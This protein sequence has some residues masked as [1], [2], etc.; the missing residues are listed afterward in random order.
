MHEF[1]KRGPRAPEF[2]D[3]NG[4]PCVN[5]WRLTAG[6]FAA[7]LHG[8]AVSDVV[9][10]SVSNPSSDTNPDNKDNKDNRSDNTSDNKS[11]S[12]QNIT[13][14]ESVLLTLIGKDPSIAQAR[15]AEFLSQSRSTVALMLARL[16]RAGLVRREGSRKTG[17]WV[18]ADGDRR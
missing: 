16:Q 12:R 14:E 11:S 5:L 9:E 1:E 17:A 3:S 4:M 2:Q 15:M 10:T 8:G 13:P 6:Q 18:V 7:C